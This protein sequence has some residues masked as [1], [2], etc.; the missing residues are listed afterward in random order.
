MEDHIRVDLEIIKEII[1]RFRKGKKY[2][3]TSDVIKEYCGGFYSNVG[4]PAHQSFNTQFG[5]ILK[6]HSKLLGIKEIAANVS[7]KDDLKRTTTASKWE[8]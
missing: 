8:I 3:F 2:I 5:K 6:K 1:D 7:L 4:I